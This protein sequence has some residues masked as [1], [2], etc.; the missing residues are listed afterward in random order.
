MGISLED[1]TVHKSSRISL[2]RV[3]ADILLIR[4]ICSGELPLHSGGE[5]GSSSSPKSAL[6]QDLDHIFGSLLRQHA[7]KR[8][9]AAGTDVFLNILR[10]DHAA[11]AQ[12][13]PVLFLIE[14]R[15]IERDDPVCLCRFIV[16][17]TCDDS[18][19]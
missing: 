5:S 13:Y 18:S 6:K 3:A 16:K 12:R 19:L 17:Q 15:L 10:I 2:V 14:V 1:R 11:V 4:I 7:A 8:L 9:I